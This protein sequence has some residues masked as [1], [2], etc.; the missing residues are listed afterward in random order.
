MRIVE[1]SDH[2]G[3]MLRREHERQ[4][5]AEENA[6]SV[7]A[8]EL[9]LYRER[10][11]AAQARRREARLRHRWLTWLRAVLAVRR[12]QARAPRRPAVSGWPSGQEEILLAGRA[13]EQRVAGDL[14]RVLD[15]AWVLFRGYRNRGGEIDHLPLAIVL[16]SAG[17]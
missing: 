2:P 1:L 7:F 12:E 9:A 11:R 5:T 17:R 13:G 15:D 10:V 8:A 3:V 4:R 16:D 6:R 14:G